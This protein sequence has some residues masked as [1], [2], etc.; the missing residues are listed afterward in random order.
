M[1]PTVGQVAAACDGELIAGDPE[2]LGREAL[3]L[4]VAAMT[5]P[6]LIERLHDGALLI[7]PG[8]RADVLLGR[9]VRARVQ[10]A[11]LR[12]AGIVLTGGL[13]PPDGD[14]RADRRLR[15]DAADH[16]DRRTTRSRRRRWPA[17]ARA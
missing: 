1:A 17:R 16:A 6:N 11:A 8:D 3:E 5:L 10:R 7:T 2:L 13:R 4:I 12:L 14:P 9:A 15:D